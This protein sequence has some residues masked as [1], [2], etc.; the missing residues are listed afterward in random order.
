MR[1]LK[2]IPV[3]PLAFLACQCGRTSTTSGSSGAGTGTGAANQV[4]TMFVVAMENHNWTQPSNQFTGG[5]QQIFQNSNAPFIN[6]LVNGTAV[7]AIGGASVNISQQVAYATAY[8]NVLATQAGNTPGLHPSEPNYIWAEAGLYLGLFSDNDPYNGGANQN[9]P[10]H[11]SN[12]LTGAGKS[13]R[14]YQEDIDLTAN[15]SG[16]LTNLPLPRTAWTVPLTSF[17]GTFAPGFF[18]AY[19]GSNQYA[20]AAKHNPMVF[21]TDTNGGNNPTSSNPLSLQYAPLQ[22]LMTDLSNGT[23][24][25]Y[26]WI[27]PDLYN[28]MH[29][30]LSGGYKGLSGDEAR[31]KQGDDFLKQIVP[32]IMASAAYKNRGAI[33]LWWDETESAAGELPDDFKHTLGEI[34][35]SPLAHPN[36]N[37]LP[38][39]SPVNFTHSSD[40][41]TMQEIFGL[42]PLL[43]DL[44]NANDLSD[45]FVSGAIP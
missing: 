17:S 32:V 40:L 11:L 38:Y 13:W 23:A 10:L 22:Q 27:T 1:N 6:S 18:N 29:T 44:V 31:I 5:T 15:G 19:N 41:R 39:A 35:I 9:S 33:I 8:H 2:W 24:A 4:T 26:N 28:D 3:I 30:A 12:L 25:S 34:V 14:S 37:G 7:A 16:Q 36:V 43:G 21:F 20:Y 45:L 42:G